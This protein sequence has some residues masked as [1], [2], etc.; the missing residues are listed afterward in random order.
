MKNLSASI[1]EESITVIWVDP[2]EHKQGYSYNV[3]W[4]SSK[5]NSDKT[6]GTTYN[7]TNL[8]PGSQ[9]NLS[10]TT[11]TFDGTQGDSKWISPCTGWFYCDPNNP[12]G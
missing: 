6:E 9:Y 8:V 11:E 1:E 2:D 4:Q 7:I 5:D 12:T 3:S 10:V